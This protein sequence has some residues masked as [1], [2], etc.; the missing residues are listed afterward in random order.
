[1]KTRKANNGYWLT[2]AEL[3]DG[4]TRCFWRKVSGYGDIENLF[5]EWSDEQKAEWEKEH[6]K[7]G[8]LEDEQD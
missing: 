4:E 8:G 2:Q 7:E 1:M 3:I 6:P 5:T